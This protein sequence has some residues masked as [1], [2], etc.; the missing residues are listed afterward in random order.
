MEVE[1]GHAQAMQ[2][3]HHQDSLVIKDMQKIQQVP[4]A[5]LMVHQQQIAQ[6]ENIMEDH[7]V[8]V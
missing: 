7:M 4:A 8:V 2:Y 6:P 5:N 1:K 3:V